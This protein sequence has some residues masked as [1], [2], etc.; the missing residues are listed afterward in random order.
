ME[1]TVMFRRSSFR[2]WLLVGVMALTGCR[3]GPEAIAFGVDTCQHCK[4]TLLDRR[5]GG[6]IVS[7]HG[8][9][10]K[11]DSLDCLHSFARSHPG[12]TSEDSQVFVLDG[13]GSGELLKADDAK[14][15]ERADLHAPMG[16]AILATKASA[17]MAVGQFLS[18]QDVQKR[19]LP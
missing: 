12:E 1:L 10:F 19:L 6:E 3:H 13:G 16:K 18:W 4:M 11:F 14:F 15:Q 9:V 8:K 7:R 2:I 5:F 17:N